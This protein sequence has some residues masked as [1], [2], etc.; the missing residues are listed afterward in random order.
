MAETAFSWNDFDEQGRYR[1]GDGALRVIFAT[2]GGGRFLGKLHFRSSNCVRAEIISGSDWS[3]D[4]G[5]P[6][7]GIKFL[8]D[9]VGENQLQGIAIDQGRVVRLESTQPRSTK[10][11]FLNNLRVA[12][13]LFAHPR[14][15]A[16]TSA[17]DTSA[18]S[19]ELIRAGIWLTPKSLAG[20]D[21]S[22]FSEL[23]AERQNELHNAVQAF[24][25]IAAK[26]PG[27]QPASPDQFRDASVAFVTIYR[28]LSPYLALAG[29]AKAVEKA[30]RKVTFPDWVVNWDY[31]LGSDSEGD[32]VVWVKV[33]ADENR[34][35]KARLA[36]AA[37]ELT[38]QVR[39]AFTDGGV[40][41]WPYIRM[42]TA[43]EHK[44]G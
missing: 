37:S 20:F 10:W 18:V 41:R 32:E 42:A 35:P 29:E 40:K 30:L 11:E 33:F 4:D 8:L 44:A 39:Q 38:Q 23:G 26:V 27:D 13:N 16:D 25:A 43:Y 21:P 34:F 36:R 22:D 6:L 5:S 1:S 9:V 31:E 12:R 19:E 14:V 17:L 2:R 7:D 15:E 28:L 3:N 24:R